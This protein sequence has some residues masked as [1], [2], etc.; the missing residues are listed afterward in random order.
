MID[1]TAIN[2]EFLGLVDIFRKRLFHL[3]VAFAIIA[4]Y[5]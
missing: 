5:R 4:A 3:F 2:V 1:S